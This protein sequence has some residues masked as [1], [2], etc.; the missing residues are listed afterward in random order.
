MSSARLSESALYR[1]VPLAIVA[2][3][4]AVLAPM[5]LPLKVLWMDLQDAGYGH[6]PLLAALVAWLVVRAS[7]P[8]DRPRQGSRLAILG[9]AMASVAWAAAAV[10]ST[11]SA[12]QALW[13]LMCWFALATAYG[14]RGARRFVLPLSLLYFALPVWGP[15][16]DLVLWP[17][18]I[19]ASSLGVQLLGMNAYVDR[20]FVYIPSGAFEIISGCSGQHFFLVATVIGLLIASLNELRGRQFAL[21]VGVAI[22]MA[23]VMNWVRVTAIIAV[24]YATEMQHPIV[25]EGHLLFGWILFAAVLVIYILWARVYLGRLPAIDADRDTNANASTKAAPTDWVTV[26]IGMLALLVGPAWYATAQASIKRGALAP[27]LLKMPISAPGWI[28]PLAGDSPLQ[29]SYPSVAIERR[30]IYQSADAALPPVHVYAN[31]YVRQEQGAE[32]VGYQNDPLPEALWRPDTLVPAAHTESRYR[33]YTV[34]TTGGERWLLRQSYAIADRLVA[35]DWQSKVVLATDALLLRAPRA[36]LV[37]L[38]TP[39]PADCRSV[40]QVMEQAWSAIVPAL[41]ENYR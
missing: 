15:L 35:G 33:E 29:P 27:V 23:V 31:L 1:F 30:A 34:V 40:E 11:T 20:N 8:A 22:V 26:S 2:L 4:T 19:K 24:G 38:A 9:L 5:L 6:G 3:A 41:L 25:A 18:T 36:G 7:S 37:L 39:C 16:T 10:S 17:L 28:G 32:L 14:L 21:V 13:P 12:A